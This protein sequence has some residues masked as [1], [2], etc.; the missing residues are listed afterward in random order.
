MVTTKNEYLSLEEMT[1]NA[2]Y[3]LDSLIYQ[4]WTRSSICAMLGNM[5][6]ESTINAGIWE[7]LIANDMSKGFGL[8]QWTPATNFTDWADSLGYSWYDIDK[9]LERINYEIDN[10]I[11]F[12]PTSTYPMTFAEFKASTDSVETLAQVFLYNYERPASLD[13]PWRSTQAR[14]WFDNLEGGTPPEPEPV[15][16][17][18]SMPIWL[19]NRFI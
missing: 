16:K 5:E 11:Q 17:K 8:V 7:N 15:T 2:Q 6:S 18:K 3:I 13:Q 1:G 4:G 10:S 19:Y 14:Y 9:Q 12:Y